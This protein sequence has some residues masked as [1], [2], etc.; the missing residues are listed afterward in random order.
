MR[1]EECRP[2]S[3]DGGD[4]W[5]ATRCVPLSDEAVGVG[6]TCIT[7]EFGPVSGYDNCGEQSMCFGVDPMSL[8]GTCVAYCQNYDNPFCED[9]TTT[10]VQGNSES[11][12]V[13]LAQC[14]PLQQD[15]AD[16][17]T[18]VGNYDAGDDSGAFF[19]MPPG[20]P[21]VNDA[22]V[23][24]ADCGMAGIGVPSSAIDTCDDDVPCCT[25]YC[26]LSTMDTCAEG[27]ACTSFLPEGEFPGE[28]NVGVCVSPPAE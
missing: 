9:P 24:P 21:Y 2:W 23:R 7:E 4:A 26:D 18:C 6:E 8:A 25:T 12:A 27:L 1:G 17:E 3:N 14:D 10:C 28:F 19:C 15:C 20:T 11:I 16:E 22:G 13:C 5:T